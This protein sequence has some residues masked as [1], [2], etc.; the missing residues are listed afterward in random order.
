MTSFLSRGATSSGVT[1]TIVS[2]SIVSMVLALNQGPTMGRS[3]RPGMR[4]VVALVVSWSSPAI[5]SVWPSRSSTT[6]RALRCVIEGTVP[7]LTVVRLCEIELADDRLDVEADHVVG[8][9]LGQE[10]EDRAEPLELDRDHGR[11]AGDRGALRDRV[12]EHAADQE[13][14]GLAVH[15]PSGWARRGS[16]PGC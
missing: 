10:G 15:A 3:P 12:R 7:P 4:I 8:Q 6:V 14:G 5:A 11:A 9:D 16:S 1:R 2:V 13:A